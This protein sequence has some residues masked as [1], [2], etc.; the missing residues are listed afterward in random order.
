MDTEPEKLV[1][2]VLGDGEAR[3]SSEQSRVLSTPDPDPGCRAAEP[4][5]KSSASLSLQGH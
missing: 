3:Q 5:P 4:E 2:N 1:G